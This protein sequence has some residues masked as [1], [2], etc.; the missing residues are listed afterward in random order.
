MAPRRPVRESSPPDLAWLGKRY[1]ALLAERRPVDSLQQELADYILPRK[2]VITERTV[3][4]GQELTDKV[5]DS[6]AIRANELLS[7][8]I[9]GTTLSTVLPWFG[10][11]YRAPKLNQVKA[12]A[13]WLEDTEERMYLAIRQSNFNSEAGEVCLDLGCFGIGAMLV[14]ERPKTAPGFAGLLQRAKPPGTYCIAE[15]GSGEVDT[16]FEKFEWS[17]RNVAIRFGDAALTEDL[18]SQAKETPDA[19][20][21]IIHAIYPREVQNPKRRDVRHLPF[22]S[23]YLTTTQHLLLED[24]YHEFPVLVPRWGQTS[25]EVYGRGPGHTALPDIRTLN[26]AIEMTLSAAS[27][28]IDP[29]GLTSSDA[30]FAELDMRSGAQN[31]V[32]GD[33]RMAWMPLES[34]AKFDVAQVLKEE[35]RASI[36]HAFYYEQLQ[37]GSDRQMTATEVERRLE[38]MQ[39]H[40]G[41]MM[42]R[43]QSEFQQR[44]IDRVF[45]L[46]FR[47]GALRR[48]PREALLGG[49]DIDIEYEGPLARSQKVARIA[50]L[51]R[52]F[53]LWLPVDA[54]HPEYGVF[55]SLDVDTAM[56]DTLD[57]AGLPS[58]YKR[59]EDQVAQ[60][61][62]LR[63]QQQ[64]M[65]RQLDQIE[66]GAT[67]AGKA[68]PALEM[69][70]GMAG[71]EQEAA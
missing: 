9:Q 8:T 58:T 56:R 41:P 19:K 68:A 55:D 22:A 1:D 42:G 52:T 4:E 60:I 33:P 46:M 5:W 61:R 32:E 7:S 48:P 15:S 16:F 66:Q 53:A 29:P 59:S 18:R 31:T 25:G 50:G 57:V 67:A 36:R 71:E 62:Q 11:K 14:E 2:A 51:E 27:K 63:Q 3:S 23:V 70:Q 49:G 10:L 69:L 24:G 40:L 34:G 12:A 38:L 47:A 39:R 13:D 35:L 17:A 44:Y 28:A 26:K 21:G 43:F 30:T 37:L 45:G 54:A 20:I 6:T 65:Q 64:A